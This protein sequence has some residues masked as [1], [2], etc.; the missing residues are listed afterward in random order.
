MI[1]SL[2]LFAPHLS[3]APF[4]WRLVEAGTSAEA[5]EEGEGLEALAARLG[6]QHPERVILVVPAERALR[7]SLSI[8]ARSRRQLEAALPY[9]FEEFLAED[10]ERLHLVAGRRTADGRVQAAAMDPG[11]LRGWLDALTEIGIE[12]RSARLDVDAL[13]LDDD[14]DVAVLVTAERC[15]V[16]T[17]DGGF[18]GERELLGTL[19]GAACARLPEGEHAVRVR[20]L[21]TAQDGGFDLAELEASLTQL[22]PVTVTR[23]LLDGSIADQLADGIDAAAEAPEF[24]AGP[25]APRRDA[26][27]TLRRW[28]TPVALAAGWFFVALLL[29]VAQTRWLDHRAQTLRSESEQMFRTIFPQRTRNILD[30]RREL[31]ALVEGS[32]AAGGASLL[33]LLGAVAGEV[34]D[35]DALILRSLS[36]NAQRGDLAVDMSVPSIAVV[37]RFKEGLERGGFPVVIDSAVQEQQGVRARVRISGGEA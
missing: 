27:P 23:R 17:A 16:R 26:S 3:D 15:L 8:P 21:S 33:Q 4:G 34:G 18:A 5:T 24:L 28:R 1:R 31:E 20:V 35:Q 9:V 36:W 14:L 7:T 6:D 11:W 30:P 13:P 22:R 25:F 10:V 19:V 2:H 12:P 32:G 29:G 37:D